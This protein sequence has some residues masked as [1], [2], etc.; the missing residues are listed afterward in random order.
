MRSLEGWWRRNW[1]K[2]SK[3][4]QKLKNIQYS[5]INIHSMFNIKISTLRVQALII[6]LLNIEWVLD[7]EYLFH[8]R[9]LIVVK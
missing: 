9:L 6:N 7:V 1:A 4:W 5:I 2:L 8:L 3:I